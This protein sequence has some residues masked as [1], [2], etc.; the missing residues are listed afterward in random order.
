MQPS[1]PEPTSAR[2]DTPSAPRFPFAAHLR[3]PPPNALRHRGSGSGQGHVESYFLRANHPQRP[4]A[5]WLKATILAPLAGEP[6]AE[7]W[8]IAFDGERQRLFAHKLTHPLARAS[9]IGDALGARIAA[10]DWLLELSERGHARGSLASKDGSAAFDLTFVPGTGAVAEPLSILPSRILR[11]GP[12]PRSKLLT[13]FPW[14]VFGGRL[15]VFGERWDLTGWN[16]MQGHNW[17]REHAFEY[18]WGQCFFPAADGAPEAMVEGF[19]GRIK[20]AGR[21]TPQLSAMVVR[22]GT[23]S[24]TFATV[25][26]FWRQEAHVGPTRW[27]LTLR[28]ADG[29][30]RLRMDAGSQ[31]MACLGYANPDRSLAY[32][33]NTKLAEV[34]LEVRPRR[35][36]SFIC[37]SAHGGALEFLRRTPDHGREVV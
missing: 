17:G 31:P 3:E 6:V 12:F 25:F 18:A 5:L 15:D 29:E 20:V 33:F 10:G 2:I 30:A 24:Y 7:T 35:E 8:L 22:R 37:V 36:P 32:C 1:F 23:R 28:S 14:L 11:E 34:H 21:P 4:L 19:T 27:T 9:M 26:D 16:G 13:P